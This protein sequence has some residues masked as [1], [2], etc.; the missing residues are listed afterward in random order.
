MH[1]VTNGT[2]AFYLFYLALALHGTLVDDRFD[3]F[4][5]GS[6]P[7]LRGMDAQHVHEL[8]HVVV[9]IRRQEM[10]ALTA[11][12]CLLYEVRKALHRQSLGHATL[13]S[14]VGNAIY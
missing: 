8:N 12:L 13:G 11:C 9:T 5:A 14:H 2:G 6:L 1:L 10:D 3:E 4:H 7:L